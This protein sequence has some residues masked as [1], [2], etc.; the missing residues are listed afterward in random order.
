VVT[1]QYIPDDLVEAEYYQPTDH[2]AERAVRERVPRLRRIVRGSESVRSQSS[3][4]SSLVET[5]ASP[6]VTP[7]KTGQVA[8]SESGGNRRKVAEPG[9]G[10]DDSGKTAGG[11]EP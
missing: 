8:E 9:T 2:G 11:E 10:Q 6:A 1:Q 4:G 5:A 7:H 3:A